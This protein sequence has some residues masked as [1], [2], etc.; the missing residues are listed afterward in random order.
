MVR[1]MWTVTVA[2]ASSIVLCGMVGSEVGGRSTQAASR[3]AGAIARVVHVPAAVASLE[4]NFRMLTLD[5]C[6]VAKELD[7]EWDFTSFRFG[8]GNYKSANRLVG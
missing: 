6:L 3:G 1:R 5:D 8:D 7:F 2:A 4:S